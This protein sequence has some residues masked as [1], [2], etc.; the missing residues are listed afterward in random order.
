V[1]AFS[2]LAVLATD[3]IT[4]QDPIVLVTLFYASV[5]FSN[6]IFKDDIPMPRIESP[7]KYYD[8]NHTSQEKEQ[9]FKFEF[10][11]RNIGGERIQNPKVEYKLYDGNG[12]TVSSWKTLSTDESVI[13]PG[14]TNEYS[15]DGWPVTEGPSVDYFVVIRVRPYLGL[16]FSRDRRLFSIP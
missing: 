7:S 3:S 15:I 8:R 4:N 16:S 9:G 5:L 12:C 11:I 1:G 10:H 13:D 14:K 2:L 6:N